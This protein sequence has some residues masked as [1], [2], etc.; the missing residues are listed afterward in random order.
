MDPVGLQHSDQP[1]PSRGRSILIVSHMLR[2]CSL[3]SQLAWSSHHMQL[4]FDFSDDKHV[5]NLD[6]LVYA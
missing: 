6:E 4:F 3:P 1:L 5:L 2:H